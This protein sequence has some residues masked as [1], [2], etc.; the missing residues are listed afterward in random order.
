MLSDDFFDVGWRK[1]DELWQDIENQTS[2][3]M[4]SKP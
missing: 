1:F 2:V 3:Q 4:I